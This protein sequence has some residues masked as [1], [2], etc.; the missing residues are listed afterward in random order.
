VKFAF[1]HAEKA[2]FEVSALCRNLEVSRQ[3][4]TLIRS[5][6]PA[7]ERLKNRLCSSD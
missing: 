4:T 3:V 5:A 7:Y 1:I 6:N 2:F